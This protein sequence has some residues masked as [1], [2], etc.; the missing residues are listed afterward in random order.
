MAAALLEGVAQGAGVLARI[1]EQQDVAVR[2]RDLGRPAHAGLVRQAP[3]AGLARGADEGKTLADRS[4]RRRYRRKRLQRTRAEIA[5]V[6]VLQAVE[7][8]VSGRRQETRHAD[9]RLRRGHA[10]GRGIGYERPA[11]CS[12]RVDRPRLGDDRRA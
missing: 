3:V 8:E 10:E 5:P 9:G 2:A 1:G 11:G 12:D 6:P 4:P 7:R